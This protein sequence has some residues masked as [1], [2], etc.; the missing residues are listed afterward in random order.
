MNIINRLTQLIADADEAYKQSIIAILNEIVPDLDV[1]SKQ[2]I[3]K[4]IC[5]DNTEVVAL[6]KSY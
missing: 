3:A 2:E 6:M 5:W 1:E 4:K